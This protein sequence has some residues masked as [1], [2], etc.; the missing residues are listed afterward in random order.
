MNDITKCP[1]CGGRTKIGICPD[2]GYV[3]PD[4]AELEYMTKLSNAEPEDYP[5]EEAARNELLSEAVK[6]K[7][8]TDYMLDAYDPEPSVK[9]VQGNK[10]NT[11]QKNIYVPDPPEP[12]KSLFE[13]INDW[14]YYHSYVGYIILAIL[15]LIFP[16]ALSIA[17]G[18]SLLIPDFEDSDPF[19]PKKMKIGA[20]LLVTGLLKWQFFN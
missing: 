8:K 16:S 1:L 15:A 10:Q 5:G 6:V 13:I 19:D 9:T 2:C 18:A 14:F 12:P 7:V 3:I 20:V 17:I 11:N 4:S